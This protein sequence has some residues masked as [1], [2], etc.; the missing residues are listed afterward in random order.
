MTCWLILNW[1]KCD[2][3]ERTGTV[4]IIQYQK[5]H[6]HQLSVQC[7]QQNFICKLSES[8]AIFPAMLVPFWVVWT[9]YSIPAHVDYFTEASFPLF[10]KTKQPL[11]VRLLWAAFKIDVSS[12]Y[13]TAGAKAKLCKCRSY[14]AGNYILCRN[15]N[16]KFH[17]APHSQASYSSPFPMTLF[18]TDVTVLPFRYNKSYMG[19]P[20]S[21]AKQAVIQDF[22]WHLPTLTSKQSP[23][24]RCILKCTVCVSSAKTNEPKQWKKKGSHWMRLKLWSIESHQWK[25]AQ[26]GAHLWDSM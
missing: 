16:V 4:P 21:K 15:L 5:L 10:L 25:Q 11:Q 12:T 7:F 6:G 8:S 24:E 3:L 13:C 18:P 1:G 26:M 19:M 2:S 20:Q 22:S 9:K 14:S 17:S 23:Q